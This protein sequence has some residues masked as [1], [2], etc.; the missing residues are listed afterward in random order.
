MERNCCLSGPMPNLQEAL[1]A[2]GNSARAVEL[3]TEMLE[4]CRECRPE[5]CP[6][7][8]ELLILAT[9]QSAAD[10]CEEE[11]FRKDA[12]GGLIPGPEL[13]GAG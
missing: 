9:V 1:L 4:H 5:G 11:T 7:I 6:G 12:M 2:P 3:L 13:A 8:G 10:R